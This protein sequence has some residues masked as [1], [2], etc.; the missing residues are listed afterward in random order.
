MKK[1]HLNIVLAL[2]VSFL[3]LA[4]LSIDA[5]AETENVNW[6]VTYTGSSFESTY[7]A[8][9]AK[10][11]NA[12]PGDTINFV[13]D[14]VNGTTGS[15]D[16]YM[17]ADV[18]KTLEDNKVATGGAY[19]YK[20]TSTTTT[21]PTIFDSKTVG[22][23]A[24]SAD[25]V[26]GLAQVDEGEGAYFSLGTIASGSSGTVT[27]SI[28]L[29]G[30]SQNN[31]YM[32]ALAQLNI[33]FGAEPTSEKEENKTEYK[34]IIKTNTI[35]NKIVNH[36]KKSIVKQVSRT[37]E[38]GN[39]IVIIDEEQVPT[40]GTTYISGSNPQTG[41][42]IIPLVVC[43]IFLLVGIALVLWYFKLTKDGKKEGV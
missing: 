9:K 32:S 21:N 43:F 8:D 28:D 39:Q 25:S 42:S 20:I 38:D 40:N 30:N 36:D 5:K 3:G 16:F 41:D 29:D 35:V 12:M 6:E 31:S 1:K 2:A 24:S 13:V 37:L 14:Y 34:T 18:L 19:S 11:S 15:A 4:G 27:I 22:G 23:D 26:V 17:S 10:L 7:E 33:R